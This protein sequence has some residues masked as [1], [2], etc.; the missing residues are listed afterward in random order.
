V[1][2]V[3]RVTK[4][5]LLEDLGLPESAVELDPAELVDENPLLR[6]FVERRSQLP[7][8]QETVEGLTA[9][10]VAYSLHSGEYRGLTWHHERAGVVWLLAARFHRSGDPDDAYPYFRELGRAGNLLPTEEDIRRQVDAQAVDF[11]RVLIEKVPAI[12]DQLRSNPGKILRGELGGRI[13]VR[14]VWEADD[15]PM[16]TVAI[17]QRL[18]PGEMQVPASWQLASLRLS[19]EC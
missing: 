13:G 9:K 17:S 4:R 11:A 15:P 8:G 18:R 19:P 1:A 12:V 3:L 5:C 14:A 6:A 7:T 10:I 16:M 2:H